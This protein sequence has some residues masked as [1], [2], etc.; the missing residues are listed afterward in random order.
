V[1]DAGNGSNG[2]SAWDVPFAISVVIPTRNE[3]GNVE[4][5]VRRLEKILPDR[6][7]EI[8]FVDDSTDNT[9]HVVNQ[10][11]RTSARSVRLLHRPEGERDGGL[12]GAVEAGLRIARAPWV[13]VMDGDLQ[14]PPEVIPQLLHRARETGADL[15]VASRYAGEGS[16]GSGLSKIRHMASQVMTRSAKLFFPDRM[17]EVSD[18]LSG[19]FLVRREAVA[20][21]ELKPRGFKILLE[22]VARTPRLKVADVPFEFGER[23]AG[24]SKASVKEGMIY[25]SQLVRLRF[26]AS[27]GR[28]SKFALV[29]ATGFGVNMV[30]FAL[31]FGAGLHYLAAAIIATQI[32]TLWLFLLTDRWVFRGRRLHYSGGARAALYVVMNNAAFLLRGPLLYAFVAGAGMNAV[33]ANFVS[34][35]ALTLVRFAIAD[36]WIWREVSSKQEF[37]HNYDVHGIV[38]VASE[39][40]LPELERFRV[41]RLLEEPTVQVRIGKLGPIAEERVSDLTSRVRA[42]RYDEGLGRFGFAAEIAKG[43]VSTSVTATPLLRGSPHVLYTNVVEPILRWAFVERG[44]TLVHAACVSFGGNA[45]FVTARTDTGKTT[46]ILKTLDNHPGAF[47]SD[48]LTVLTPEGR[49]L[50]YPKPLTVSAHT[51]GAVKTPLL[52]RRQ[53]MGLPLQ[54]RLHSRS[55]RQFGFLL[56]KTGLPVATINALV[57]RIVPPPKYDIETLIPGVDVAE[58]AR[59]AGVVIIERGEDEEINLSPAEATAIVLSNCEDAYGFPPYDDIAPFLHGTGEA[60]LHHQEREIVQR[61]LATLPARLIRSSTMD[62]WLR[63]PSVVDGIVPGESIGSTDSSGNGASGNGSTSNG[64]GTNGSSGN[65]AS[66][67]VAPGNGS[68]ENDAMPSWA[69]LDDAEDDKS[70]ATV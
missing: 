53:R 40:R 4:P 67:H 59:L 18:P 61:A 69:S 49:V 39:A 15:V 3:A 1:G 42:V 21:D 34:L 7:L 62:W 5:L 45:V 12:G 41:T 60:D 16:V 35:V 37:E 58:Q 26:G 43:P 2:S 36:S 9:P 63:L 48:D 55:G 46:T 57:Q 19:F 13:C 27:A 51:V 31:M 25:L 52:S 32:S 10:V 22:I 65:G 38:T 64:S 29:G 68:L 17:S 23:N 8:I 33:L 70:Q 56:A 66:E 44:H 30:A 24:E 6:P 14:H 47:I 20:L 50:T 54:S 11:G 28:F